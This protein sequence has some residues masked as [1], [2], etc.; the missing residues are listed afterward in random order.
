M[1]KFTIFTVIFSVAIMAVVA[2]LVVNDYVGT[3]VIA[4]NTTTAE[5]AGSGNTSSSATSTVK[6]SGRTVTSDLLSQAGFTQP[7]Y[8][9]TVFSGLLF[10]L[11][12][13]S[14]VSSSMTVFQG[15]VFTDV[16]YA[17]TT[18]EFALNTPE[19]TDTFYQFLQEK[20]AGVSGATLNVTNTY[21]TGSFYLNSAIKTKT[22][23]LVVKKGN[24]VYAFEYPHENHG[25]ITA[26]IG[27]L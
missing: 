8:K 13:L 21:G 18:T 15:N 2:D 11:I 17:G 9:E 23:F 4:T 3:D 1:Q 5:Q 19:Q 16:T 22:A 7:V 26:L 12:D 25:F 24:K 10:S 20:A 6:P 14:T 27:L